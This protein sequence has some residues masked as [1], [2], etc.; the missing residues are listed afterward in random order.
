MPSLRSARPEDYS[1]IVD[2]WHTGWHGAHANLVPKGILEFRTIAHFWLWLERSTDQFYVAMDGDLLGFVALNG[3]E[4]VKMYV[5]A[6]A[7]GTGVAKTLLTYAEE[8]M[9]KSGVRNAVLF[10]TAGNVRAQTFYGRQGWRLG[11]TFP[12]KLWL[13]DV[14]FEEFVVDTHRYEKFLT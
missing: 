6:D 3:S 9:A 2:I 10:C 13:P 12:D 7:Q 14:K 11:D 8:R 1:A 4:L 5:A